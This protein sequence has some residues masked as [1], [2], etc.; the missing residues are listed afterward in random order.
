MFQF[1]VSIQFSFVFK[2]SQM[3]KCQY[4]KKSQWLA[5]FVCITTAIFIDIRVSLALMLG[6]CLKGGRMGRSDKFLFG[7]CHY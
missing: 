2:I 4:W 3:L 1:N 7:V 5:C 6:L